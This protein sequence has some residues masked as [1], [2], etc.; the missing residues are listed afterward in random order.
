KAEVEAYLRRWHQFNVLAEGEWDR[1]KGLG[2]D[3]L[4]SLAGFLADNDLGPHAQL[5]IQKSDTDGASP[6]VL[7]HPGPKDDH[8]QSH[9]VRA[10]N[11]R[12]RYAGWYQNLPRDQRP[13]AKQM[14]Y[15]S[16]EPFP[17]T[18]EMHA[19]AVRRVESAIKESASGGAAGQALLTLGMVGTKDDLP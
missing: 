12:I 2:K 18:K 7:Q 9:L 1:L 5:A 19:A 14:H 3:V 10:A 15:V 11:V 17:H 13:P 8:A 4:P 6:L 16:C